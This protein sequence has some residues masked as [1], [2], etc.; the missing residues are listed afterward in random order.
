MSATGDDPLLQ[1]RRDFVWKLG[2]KMSL[3]DGRLLLLEEVLLDFSPDDFESL[4][5]LSS[6]DKWVWDAR[7]LAWEL[8]GP[9]VAVWKATR[10]EFQH[11]TPTQLMATQLMTAQLDV[12]QAAY[13][14]NSQL[15]YG[16]QRPAPRRWRRFMDIISGYKTYALAALVIISSVASSLGIEVSPGVKDAI[17]TIMLG[18]I[19]ALNR[20]RD[21]RNAAVEAPA[22]SPSLEPKPPKPKVRDWG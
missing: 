18:V 5:I 8:T 21:K 15:V 20:W 6:N 7:V 14:M 19:L 17:V 1:L 22:L 2:H 16:E 9:A 4:E 10:P 13:E 3:I 12:R 11:P